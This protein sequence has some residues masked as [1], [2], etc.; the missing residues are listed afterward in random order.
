MKALAIEQDLAPLAGAWVAGAWRWLALCGFGLWVLI[1]GSHHEPWFDEAQAWLL[2]R[3][4]S[5]WDLLAHRVRYEGTPGLWHAVLWCAIRAGLPYR[6]FFVIP[7]LFAISGAA[8]VLWKAPFP[9]PLRMLTVTS[10][11]YGYQFSIVARSYCLDLLLVP[12]AAAWFGDRGERPVRYALVLALIANA[13]AHGFI[14]ATILG[15]ELVWQVHRQNRINRRSVAGLA[16]AAALGLFALWCA[17][18]PAD[19]AF[20]QPHPHDNPVMTIVVYLCHAF[21]DHIDVWDMAQVGTAEIFISVIVTIVV[22]RPVIKL[23]LAGRERAMCLAVLGS[24]LLFAA[25]VYASMWHA[26]VFLLFWLFIVWVQWRNRLASHDRRQ[27]IAALAIVLGLQTTQTLR[28]GL[29]DIAN[30]YAPGEQAAQAI[31]AWRAAHPGG[32]IYGYGDFAFSVQPW[33]AGNPF[34]NYHQGDPKMSYVRWDRDEPWMAG[35]WQTGTARLFWQQVLAGKPDLIVAS[36]VNRNWQ[37]G[38]HADLVPSACR[39]GYGVRQ[40]LPGTMI[41][42]G[43]LTEDETLYLF[44]RR[45]SGPCAAMHAAH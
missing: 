31:T 13:N 39:A 43:K 16:F 7:A 11:F 29:W 5:L 40:V 36:L 28:S 20:W 21:V 1:V 24:L 2:A 17:W 35:A 27:L 42:R 9:A 18:Q 15:M 23:I 12:V 3:D 22:Q 8:V 25:L 34:A 14:V 10:Y 26:G 38:Y 37:G 30:V 33:L 32:R 19:N 4:N 41:W 44:E 6:L 45:S